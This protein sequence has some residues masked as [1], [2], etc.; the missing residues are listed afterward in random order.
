LALK[1]AQ[2]NEFSGMDTFYLC[3]DEITGIIWW[4][5]MMNIQWAKLFWGK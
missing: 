1:F 4:Y 5:L 3:S 2:T